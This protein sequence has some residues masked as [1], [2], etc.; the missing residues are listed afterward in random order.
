M[1]LFEYKHVMSVTLFVQ[2]KQDYFYLFFI[3]GG[4][5]DLL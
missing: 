3:Y 5:K 1:K 4:G 2:N